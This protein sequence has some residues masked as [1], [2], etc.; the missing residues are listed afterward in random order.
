MRNKKTCL[1]HVLTLRGPKRSTHCQGY[2]FIR[3]KIF[4]G[5]FYVIYCLS[6][7]PIP[8][9]LDLTMAAGRSSSLEDF[10]GSGAKIT[11]RTVTTSNHLASI[12]FIVLSLF[13]LFSGWSIH[14]GGWCSLITMKAYGDSTPKLY[15]NFVCPN[16]DWIVFKVAM[17]QCIVLCLQTKNWNINFKD[18]VHTKDK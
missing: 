4:M 17:A 3:P 5:A 18:E 1:L 16:K 2:F 10:V 13:P 14:T 6:L 11:R 15:S 9:N 7:P 8:P 12:S